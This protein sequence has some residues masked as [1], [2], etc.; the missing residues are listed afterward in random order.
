MPQGAAV[1]HAPR[2]MRLAGQWAPGGTG[3]VSGWP[4]AATPPV[5]I[6]LSLFGLGY[7]A[8][9]LAGHAASLGPA[10]VATFW[11]AAGL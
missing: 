11:P 6:L 8:G 4:S 7:L 3:R 5:L 1:Q 9:A 10:R 2:S